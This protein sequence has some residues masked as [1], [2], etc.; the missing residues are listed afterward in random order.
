MNQPTSRRDGFDLSIHRTGI[1]A[2]DLLLGLEP[3]AGCRCNPASGRMRLPVNESAVSVP[4]HS[5]LV[6]TPELCPAG[7][8]LV[9]REYGSVVITLELRTMVA[10][11]G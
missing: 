10:R 1:I 11:I 3:F 9:C 4:R 6:E 5:A 2:N 7:A 8:S